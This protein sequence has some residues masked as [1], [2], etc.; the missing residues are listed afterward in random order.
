MIGEAPVFLRG[1]V[2]DDFRNLVNMELV[3]G[4]LL[5]LDDFGYAIVGEKLAS[6][7][8]L[9]VEDWVILFSSLKPRYIELKIKGIFSSATS[10]DDEILVSI[11]AGQWLRG[12]DYGHATLIRVEIDNT[13][14]STD[15][16][17]AEIENAINNTEPGDVT[18]NSGQPDLSSSFTW[19][20][21]DLDGIAVKDVQNFMEDQLGQYGVT[22]NTLLI[23][24]II[25]FVFSTTGAFVALRTL[26]YQHRHEL[27]ALRS[28]GASSRS[29]KIDWLLKILP[30]STFISLIGVTAS[31]IVL[32]FINK[33]AQLQAFSHTIDFQVEP[34]SIVL[35]VILSLFITTIAIIWGRWWG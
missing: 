35:N 1:T 15:V 16:L 33:Y 23:L 31:S 34:F 5:E 11:Y 24:S 14:T 27:T 9:N 21:F 25:V 20:T 26:Q 13:K 19:G 30:Y 3:S 4:K 18:S 8:D 7:L 6:R 2:P 28:I 22:V 12:T 32:F 10:I 29:L 17:W